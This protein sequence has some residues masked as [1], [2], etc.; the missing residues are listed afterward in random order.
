MN[1]SY[2]DHGMIR[3]IPALKTLEKSVLGAL[4]RTKF[5]TQW[6]MGFSISSCHAAPL[7]KMTDDVILY[8]LPEA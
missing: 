2:F 6:A 3:S 8:T 4:I 5:A 1:T 7:Q